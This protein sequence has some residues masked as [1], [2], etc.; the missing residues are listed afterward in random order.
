MA[1]PFRPSVKLKEFISNQK[2]RTVKKYEK[3]EFNSYVE[4]TNEIY[5][6]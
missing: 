5:I 4:P 1:I 6:F 3:K 2:Q